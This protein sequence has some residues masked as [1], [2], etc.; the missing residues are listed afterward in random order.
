M[1]RMVYRIA[2]YDG[3]ISTC[4]VQ[5][6]DLTTANIDAEYAAGIA[7]QA[8]IDGVSL[9]LVL[10]KEHVAKSSPQAVGKASN[11]SAQREAKALVRFYDSVTFERGTME[12]PAVDLS[13]QLDGHPGFFY[14]VQFDGDENAAWTAFVAAMIASAVGPGGN[15]VVVDTI[16]HVG[17]NL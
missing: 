7:I 1:G 14:D 2:D 8:A 9:G 17:R 13:L 6:A 11:A 15:D 3:E 5:T 4:T 12:I 10:N 16:I